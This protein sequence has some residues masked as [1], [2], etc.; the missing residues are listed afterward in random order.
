MRKNT[1]KKLYYNYIKFSKT[2]NF[3]AF[4]VEKNIILKYNIRRY[5]I[6]KILMK[7]NE[8][9]IIL[10]YKFAKTA[11]LKKEEAWKRTWLE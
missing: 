2:S 8:I 11:N 9:I 4:F 1:R 5:Y 10:L 7:F 3:R 6:R